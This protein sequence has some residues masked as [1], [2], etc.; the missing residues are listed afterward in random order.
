[1]I[2]VN[3]VGGICICCLTFWSRSSLLV[4]MS[5]S[6]AHRDFSLLLSVATALEAAPFEDGGID[7]IFQEAL[8]LFWAQCENFKTS[9]EG[10]ELALR[11]VSPLPFLA[12]QDPAVVALVLQLAYK[13]VAASDADEGGSFLTD[14]GMMSLQEAMEAK[15]VIDSTAKASLAGGGALGALMFRSEDL[16]QAR[17]IVAAVLGEFLGIL[18]PSERSADSPHAVQRLLVCLLLGR[19][20]MGAA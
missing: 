3:F 18:S 10:L 7:S 15:E 6:L 11:G 8:L 12:G 2:P 13:V 20:V 19:L 16:S 1:M 4:Q 17:G 14:A 9:W 5:L